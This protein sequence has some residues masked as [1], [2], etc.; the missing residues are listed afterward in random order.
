MPR[1]FWRGTLSFGLVEIPVSLRPAVDEHELSFTLLDRKDFSPVGYKRYNKKSGR[2]VPW[3][4][5]VR[6]Y[7]Y[8]KDE[9]VVLTDEELKSAY[10]EATQTIEILEFVEASE[11][12]PMLFDA[13]YFLEPQKKFSKGYVLLRAAL[14]KT[15]KAGIGRLVLRTRQRLCAIVPKD[16][17][18]VLLLLRYAYELREPAIETTGKANAV[19]KA[20]IQ[21]AERLIG[22]MTV[23]WDPEQFKDEYHDD[24]LALVERK[25][26]AGQTQEILAGK[27]EKRPRTARAEVMDLMP[28]LKQS[29]AS[30]A[31]RPARAR[32]K[33]KGAGEERRRRSAS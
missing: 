7:E 12:D 30:R 10:P 19:S 24:V 9:Y 4:Q 25:V 27:G 11:L 26:K 21:M 29:L 16:E 32:A 15:G 6:G 2:E 22:D 20:E 13:P 14:A 3:D 18:L 17:A 8:D 33:R 5:I 31:K 1:S 28:L 23:K